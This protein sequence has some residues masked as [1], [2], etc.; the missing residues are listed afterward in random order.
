MKD[1]IITSDQRFELHGIKRK[2]ITDT[3]GTQTENQQASG[4]KTQSMIDT[5]ATPIVYRLWTGEFYDGL[6]KT[7]PRYAARPCR[8]W[9]AVRDSNS[10][11]ID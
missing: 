7:K 3:A 11:P 1:Q 4:H 6:K 2:G 5:R 9:W 10:G 8:Y